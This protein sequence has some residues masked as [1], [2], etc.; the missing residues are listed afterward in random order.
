MKE[1]KE[2]RRK[3]CSRQKNELKRTTEKTNKEYLDTV[4]YKIVEF[5]RTQR[6]DLVH[7]KKQKLV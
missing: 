6:F 4:R 3:Y 7:M 1:G 2:K 5:Q